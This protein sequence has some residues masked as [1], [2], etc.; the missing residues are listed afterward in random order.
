MCIRDRLEDFIKSGVEEGRFTEMQAHQDLQI[1]LWYTFAC[2]NLD[3]YIHY[4]QA[5]EWM[6]DSEKSAAGCATWYYRYS[7]L[8]YT[9][10]RKSWGQP[11]LS[12][13]MEHGKA[14]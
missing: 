9:S 4:Y 8:L 3:D 6:K 7:C 10:W 5:A 12:C 13:K 2:L 11:A 14:P 1:A